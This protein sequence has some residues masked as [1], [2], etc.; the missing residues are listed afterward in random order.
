MRFCKALEW[1][2]SYEVI[3]NGEATTLT[4]RGPKTSESLLSD[5][6]KLTRMANPVEETLWRIENGFSEVHTQPIRKLAGV[7]G[8]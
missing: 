7:V 2:E 8:A 3:R 5:K 1:F 6:S 4:Q